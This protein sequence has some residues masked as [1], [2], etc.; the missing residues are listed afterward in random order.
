MLNA[1]V[2]WLWDI[3]MLIVWW[4]MMK[5]YIYVM[6]GPECKCLNPKKKQMKS[7]CDMKTNQILVLTENL[8]HSINIIYYL[9]T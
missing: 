9:Y 4:M 8:Q 2:V 1:S 6:Y 5:Q 7:L 3:L